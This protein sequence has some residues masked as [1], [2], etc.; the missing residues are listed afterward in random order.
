MK[1]FAKE[2]LK[3]IKSGADSLVRNEVA[4]LGKNEEGSPAKKSCEE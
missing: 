3:V 2:L 4:A 1:E